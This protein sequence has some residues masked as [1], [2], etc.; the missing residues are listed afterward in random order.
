MMLSCV[1]QYVVC[2]SLELSLLSS[3]EIALDS[4]RSEVGAAI[5]WVVTADIYRPVK[6][7]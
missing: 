2:S 4:S 3:V 6:Q 7:N 1:S 5:L